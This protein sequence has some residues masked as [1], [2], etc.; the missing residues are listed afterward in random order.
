MV[1]EPPPAPPAAPAAA[2]AAPAAAPPAAPSAPSS[3]PSD[4]MTPA[5]A[6]PRETNGYGLEQV[7]RWGGDGEEVGK[8]GGK[9]GTGSRWPVIPRG[10]KRFCDFLGMFLLSNR[11]HWVAFFDP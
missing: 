4:P 6:S 5:G 2:P 10:E 1:P 9:M 8:I 7:P 3:S 11:L